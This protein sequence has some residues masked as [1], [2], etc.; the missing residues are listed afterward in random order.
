LAEESR[1]QKELRVSTNDTT[2]LFHIQVAG[3]RYNCAWV[4]REGSS[5]VGFAKS[6][7]S[8]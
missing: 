8:E 7:K 4:T 5:A 2:G 6:V 3:V 1:P